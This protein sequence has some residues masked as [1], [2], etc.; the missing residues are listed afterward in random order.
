MFGALSRIPPRG[1]KREIFE[2]GKRRDDRPHKV[3]RWVPDPESWETAKL[4]WEMRSAGASYREINNVT[5]LYILVSGYRAFF[6]N[7]LYLGEMVFADKVIKDYVPAMIDQR[8][9]NLAQGYN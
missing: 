8:T 2:I 1:F 5:H 7:R 6:E 9:W 3:A 4:A